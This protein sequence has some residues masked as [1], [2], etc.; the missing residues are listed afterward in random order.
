M[1]R[2]NSPYSAKSVLWVIRKLPGG[3]LITFLETLVTVDIYS[4]LDGKEVSSNV[5]RIL[6]VWWVAL[7]MV[8]LVALMGAPAFA[9]APEGAPPCEQGTHP[10]GHF[11]AEVG[12]QPPPSFM[13]FA[14]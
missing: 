2:G 7:V 8:A 6:L 10:T 3:F 12:G 5:R 14:N 1:N 9:A 13:C 4:G 11:I